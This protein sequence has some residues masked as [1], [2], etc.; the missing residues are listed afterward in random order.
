MGFEDQNLPPFIEYSH[1][2]VLEVQVVNSQLAAQDDMTSHSHFPTVMV[3]NSF[4]SGTISPNNPF[5]LYFA[6]AMVFY[7]SSGK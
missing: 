2:L 5:L 7:H 6:L 4:R 1:C 3:M